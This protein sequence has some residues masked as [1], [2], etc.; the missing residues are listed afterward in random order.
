[1]VSFRMVRPF[2]KCAITGLNVDLRPL[3]ET[4]YRIIKTL[5]PKWAASGPGGPKRHRS[6]S[7]YLPSEVKEVVR[8]LKLGNDS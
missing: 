7:Q 2:K 1:M 3:F 8:E 6:Y 5:S 4:C